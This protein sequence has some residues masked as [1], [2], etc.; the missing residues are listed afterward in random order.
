MQYTHKPIDILDLETSYKNGLRYYHCGDNKYPSITSVLGT[1]PK[2][3]LIE[4]RNRLGNSA[5]DKEMQRCATRGTNVH[6]LAETYLNNL[7]RDK[8]KYEKSD[9]VMFNKLKLGLSK[10]DNILAQE[11]ALY[12]DFLE[13]AGRCDV[14]AEYNGKLS[15]IDFKTSNGVK[16]EEQVF[17]YF[18]QETFYMMAL[19]EQTGI[20]AA[21]IVTIIAVEKQLAPQ[22]FIKSPNPYI[23]PLMRRIDKFY[24]R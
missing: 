21:Q 9:I 13:V 22:I 8:A 20:E 23:K 12:S 3:Y 1:E 4:W 18:L 24:K 14:V 10:I 2:P 19:L 16:T 11:C 17:D 5:A 6:T 7:E 15:I